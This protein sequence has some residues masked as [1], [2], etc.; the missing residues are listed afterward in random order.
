MELVQ[1]IGRRTDGQHYRRCQGVHLTVPA[2]VRGTTEGE[3]GL[4]SKHVHRQ[5]ARCNPLF[6]FLNFIIIKMKSSDFW[7]E[8]PNNER[9]WMWAR[10]WIIS[11]EYLKTLY[12]FWWKFLSGQMLG[13]GR[14]GMGYLHKPSDGYW[15]WSVWTITATLCA[16]FS[17]LSG[18]WCNFTL[19]KIA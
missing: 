18:I 6:H 8:N 17:M 4:I 13:Q 7:R 1:E 14:Y 10:F 15:Y 2:A 3:C 9:I 16:V 12:G 11:V 5:L 19:F